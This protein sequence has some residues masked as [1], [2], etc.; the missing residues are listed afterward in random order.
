MQNVVINMC[1]KFHYDRFRNDRAL[2]NGTSDNKNNNNNHNNNVGSAWGTVSG[3]T[4]RCN[5]IL[6]VCS[7]LVVKCRVPN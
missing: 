4:K 2:G 1:E 3:S 7:D 6:G 5:L